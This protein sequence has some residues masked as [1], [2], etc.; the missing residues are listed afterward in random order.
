[1][2]HARAKLIMMTRKSITKLIG[3]GILLFVIGFFLGL[4]W[5]RYL[6]WLIPVGSVMTFAGVFLFFKVTNVIEEFAKDKSED[7]LTYFWNTIVLKLW[8]LIFM[9]WMIPTNIILLVNG[10][11]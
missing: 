6:Q 8:T 1:M 10:A 11:I 5:I 2:G 7:V 3:F 9:L 4:F